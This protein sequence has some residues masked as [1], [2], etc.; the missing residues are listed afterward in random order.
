M[1]QDDVLGGFSAV[2]DSFNKQN[3]PDNLDVDIDTAVGG[4]EGSNSILSNIF[5]PAN[6]DDDDAG[7]GDAGDGS[8]IKTDDDDSSAGK[9]DDAP[10]G[11]PGSDESDDSGVESLVGGFFDAIAEAAG[12]S[13]ITDDER[14]KSVE[15]LVNYMKTV[16]DSSSNPVYSNDDV[17]ALDEYVRNGGRMEDF[18]SQAGG[19]MDLSNV[20]LTDERVQRSLVREFLSERG[21]TDQ[22]INRKLEKYEEADILEDEAIDAVEALRDIREDKKKALL[23]SQKNANEQMIQE[24]QK[25]YNSVIGEIEALTDIRGIQIPKTDKQALMDYM[26]KVDHDGRTQYIKDYS[27]HPKHFI[28]SAYFTMKGDALLSSAKK[29]GET[30]AVERLKNTLNSTKVGG[31]KQRINNRSARPLW[32]V[33]STQLQGGPK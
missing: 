33:V 24:Q 6:D 7:A 17:A 25:F 14:P 8:D 31:S 29:S 27:K 5:S 18:L 11:E 23:E 1:A 2:F 4:E 15:D 13:D 10:G 12:W 3:E 9:I 26:F 16:V 28:E 30:S 22:Q 20:D 21:F 32:S 19:S